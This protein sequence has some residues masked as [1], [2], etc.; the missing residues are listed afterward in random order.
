MVFLVLTQLLIMC[1]PRL[2]RYAT[3]AVLS[4]QERE[5]ERD[6]LALI[7]VALAAAVARIASRLCIF[8]TGRKVEFAIRDEL[9]GH[10]ETLAPSFYARIPVGQ[11]M[12]RLTND[13][14]QVRMMLGMG[15]I[16]LSN[17]SLT[18]LVAVPLLFFADP[19]LALLSLLALPI[20]LVSGRRFAKSV[21]LGN[22]EAQ[23][24]LGSL[25]AK[26]RE[27]LTGAMTVRVYQREPEEELAFRQLSEELLSANMKLARLRGWMLA[28]MGAA[29]SFG[30]IVVLYV[31]GRRI[32]EGAMTVGQ[33]VEFSGYLAMLT[34]PTVGLGHLI[35][36]WQ[37][38]LASMRRVNDVFTER[39][40]IGAGTRS[41]PSKAPERIEIR[42]LSYAYPKASKPALESISASIAQ[43]QMIAV[44]GRT[45]SGKTTLLQALARLIEISRDVVFL[46][47]IDVND[48]PLDYVRSAIAYAPQ[49]AFLFSRTIKENVAF[50]AP[51]ASLERIE[52]AIEAAS[53]D[54]DV[55]S[56]P[57]GLA[58]AVGERGV[59][60]SGGQRQRTAL[61]RALVV[62]PSILLLDDVL[63][64]V[65]TRVEARIVRALVGRARGQTVI[66]A[67]HRLAVAAH[68]DRILVMEKGRLIEQGTERELL[69][70]GG[71]YA[72]MHRRQRLEREMEE[73]MEIE[74]PDQAIALSSEVAG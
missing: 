42:S 53:F 9:F 68:A 69:Q 47:G 3:D 48:L 54:E 62:E 70:L 6:A 27:N 38:G 17:T 15:V 11:V 14:V 20:L 66:V 73:K 22:V 40:T 65:D 35:S 61:A 18:F 51:E 19:L 4:A 37:R 64:A 44:V 56:F 10:L 32:V 58:T 57:D 52:V 34:G 55:R 26:V 72:E 12:S 39:P 8:E 24:R 25:S 50:G 67:T 23:E 49:E 41:A 43:G 74:E 31:G 1:V 21:F 71:I 5:I 36:Q 30:A 13:L 33:F 45:G 60:L 28:V 29:G 63:S 59:M 16:N 7:G 46:D 2:L